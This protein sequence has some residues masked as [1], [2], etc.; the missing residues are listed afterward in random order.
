[1]VQIPVIDLEAADVVERLAEAYGTVGFAQ[2]VGHR[3]DPSLVAAVFDASAQFHAL[4]AAK[5]QAVALDRNHRGYIAIDTST[6]RRSEIEAVSEPNQSES[7]MMLREAG[8]ADPDVAA[9]HYLAGANQWPEL[10]GFRDPLERFAEAMEPL[11]RR[12]IGHFLAALGGPALPPGAMDRPTTWVRLLRYPARPARASGYGSAP[13]VDF[14]AI[15][16]LAQ[17]DVGGL[18]VRGPVGEW[19]D[20]T[21][22]PGAFVLNTGSVM[23]RWSNGR[24][25]ATPHRVVNAPDRDRYSVAYFLDP[26]VATVIDSLVG[27]S[28]EEPYLFGDFLRA[29]LESGYDQHRREP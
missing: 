16:L 20:V 24:F 11:G 4:P 9:G 12:I 26:H 17:D 27:R 6:D 25:A 28:P 23:R 29:E 13:H 14:G 10:P 2:V 5:K 8:P 19:L 21:P 7:F 18:Q 15:T 22:I 3:V 1:V